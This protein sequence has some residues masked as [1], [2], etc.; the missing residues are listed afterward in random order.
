MTKIAVDV[1]VLPSKA[2]TNQS[3]KA[4]KELLRQIPERIV[5]DKENCMP[6]I[7]LAMGCINEQD[8]PEIETI[9]PK[10]ADKCPPGQLNITGISIGTNS[11]GEKVSSFEVNK[12][13]NL[14]LLHEEVMRK[15][16][17]YFSYDVTEEMVLSPPK[18]GESTL[19]WIKNYPEKSA[20]EN[21]FPHITLGYGEISD[22]SYT[23]NFRPS[24]LALCHMGNH[25]TCRKILAAIDI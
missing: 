9:L 11:I 10:I 3:I 23:A 13:E 2:I 20:F 21:F 6:H 22:L 15:M 7:S 18:A 14:L 8:I 16:T 19:L 1:V 12:T 4:N 24:K 17:P 25:C 5:L